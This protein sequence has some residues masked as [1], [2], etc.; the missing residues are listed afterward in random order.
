MWGG[1]GE[2]IFLCLLVGCGMG[3]VV[4]G[5][6]RAREVYISLFISRVWDGS[7][8]SRCGEG[9]GSIYFFVY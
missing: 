4:V 2:Y 1:Q 9:K 3:V 7:G 5:V 8:G 6:G